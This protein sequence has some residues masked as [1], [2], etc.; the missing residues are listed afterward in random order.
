M[1]PFYRLI[2]RRSEC[3]GVVGGTAANVEVIAEVPGDE[4][5]AARVAGA[6]PTRA[7]SLDA[8]FDALEAVLPMTYRLGEIVP[9]REITT[10]AITGPSRI[11]AARAAERFLTETVSTRLATSRMVAAASIDGADEVTPLGVLRQWYLL[12][13]D[14]QGM[15]VVAAGDRRSFDLVGRAASAGLAEAIDAAIPRHAAN[16][17]H[18]MTDFVRALPHGI[19]LRAFGDAT[20]LSEFA[21]ECPDAI[22]RATLARF[23][24]PS[25]NHPYAFEVAAAFAPERSLRV[26]PVP[27]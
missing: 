6:V 20:A 23:G 7:E 22:L 25:T 19:W 24:A 5:A 4:A 14:W 17:E 1:E 9:L 13:E 10:E 18:W 12:L 8:W 15:T 27:V 3:V 26:D 11:P 2:L 16:L 21:L